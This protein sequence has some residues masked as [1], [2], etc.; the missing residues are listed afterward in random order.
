MNDFLDDIDYELNN[1]K[2]LN[3]IINGEEK[4]I[5]LDLVK[6]AEYLNKKIAENINDNLEKAEKA[7]NNN[8]NVILV[9]EE[10]NKTT[11]LKK[12]T[13]RV[14]RADLELDFLLKAT[15][16]FCSCSMVFQN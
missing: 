2:A 9:E 7:D 4:M 13:K 12:K 14:L 15:V 3:I 6:A 10:G 1:N 8:N 5:E 11:Y 16:S